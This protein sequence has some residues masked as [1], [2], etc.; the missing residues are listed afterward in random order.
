M[1]KS[2]WSGVLVGTEE[3][4][5][6]HIMA[7]GFMPVLPRWLL[8]GGPGNG[9]IAI[10]HGP[11]AITTRKKGKEERYVKYMEIAKTGV[12]AVE[13]S[14]FIIRAINGICYGIQYCIKG[15]PFDNIDPVINLEAHQE[16]LN[17]GLLLVHYTFSAIYSISNIINAM[18][19]I[20]NINILN[21]FS[22]ALLPFFNTAIYMIKNVLLLDNCDAYVRNAVDFVLSPLP[23]AMGGD[24]FG[25]CSA[26]A[27]RVVQL[28][29]PERFSLLFKTYQCAMC[30]LDSESNCVIRSL[31][32]VKLA[33][34]I[35]DV[36]HAWWYALAFKDDEPGAGSAQGAGSLEVGLAVPAAEELKH[37]NTPCGLYLSGYA[38]A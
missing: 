18:Y 7:N 3:P 25:A 6:E 32:L 12:H 20:S 10:P 11:I 14:E 36:A 29:F 4:Q 9:P 5:A 21:T 24:I 27:A 26:V 37:G 8:E 28:A 31:E 1:C 34:S 35:W 38:T 16:L 33:Y 22:T 13:N 23:S 19:T 2:E 17:K 30:C 15:R